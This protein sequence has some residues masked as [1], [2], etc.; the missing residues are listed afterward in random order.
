MSS[1]INLAQAA[2]LT[3]V[4]TV[5]GINVKNGPPETLDAADFPAAV[6]PPELTGEFRWGPRT[7]KQNLVT[8]PLEIHVARQDLATDIAASLDLGEAVADAIMATQNA[9]SA[10]NGTVEAIETIKYS[11]RA[12]AWSNV[13]TLGWRFDITVRMQSTLGAG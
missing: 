11:Y 13:A 12:M 7:A 10:L 2:L 8:L 5:A 4:D 9:S 3:V 6:I 1:R